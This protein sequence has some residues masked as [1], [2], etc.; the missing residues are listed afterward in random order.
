MVTLTVKTDYRKNIKIKYKNASQERSNNNEYLNM[1]QK[2]INKL[3]LVLYIK[4][5]F[6]LHTHW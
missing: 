5:I 3:L 4:K 2:Y 6:V 1:K